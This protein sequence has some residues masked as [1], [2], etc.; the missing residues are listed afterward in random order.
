MREQD[1]INKIF[2]VCAELANPGVHFQTEQNGS[3]TWDNK[4]HAAIQGACEQILRAFDTFDEEYL[5]D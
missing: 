1:F 2:D 3:R 4:L 5:D